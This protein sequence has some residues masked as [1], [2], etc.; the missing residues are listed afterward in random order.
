MTLFIDSFYGD[1]CRPLRAGYR[2]KNECPL[3]TIIYVLFDDR[4]NATATPAMPV[5][6]APTV[7]TSPHSALS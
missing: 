3:I 6:T 2:H 4:Y 7:T 1:V 5:T